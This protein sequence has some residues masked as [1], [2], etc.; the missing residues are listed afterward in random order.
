[1]YFSLHLKTKWLCAFHGIIWLIGRL[2]IRKLQKL[3]QNIYIKKTLKWKKSY[4]NMSVPSINCILMSPRNIQVQYIVIW[5]TVFLW[6]SCQHRQHTSFQIDDTV[7]LICS[8][9]FVYLHAFS[10]PYTVSA[11]FSLVCFYHS[12][13]MPPV[14]PLHFILQPSPSLPLLFFSQSCVA[15]QENC[16]F[17][18]P[19]TSVIDPETTKAMIMMDI[20]CE[21]L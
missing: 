17:F 1:M 18:H 7:F 13:F 11:L 10:S 21:R 12:F 6:L 8:F 5:A 14:F 19:R 3:N 15:S 4:I 9:A 16:W 2:T 20:S